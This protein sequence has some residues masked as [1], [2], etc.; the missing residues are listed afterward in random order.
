MSR[1]SPWPHWAWAASVVD[2]VGSKLFFSVCS[3]TSAD[4]TARTH[5]HTKST[6]TL[7]KQYTRYTLVQSVSASTILAVHTLQGCAN[8][9]SNQDGPTQ[10]WWWRTAGWTV[11]AASTVRA[12]KLFVPPR[13]PVWPDYILGKP[14]TFFEKSCEFNKVYNSFIGVGSAM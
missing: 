11:P 3:V 7:L 2:T 10:L 13:R 9:C 6:T 1:G 4:T 8:R 5:S 14:H 12:V